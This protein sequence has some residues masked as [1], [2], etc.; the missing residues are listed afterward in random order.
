MRDFNYY[1][2]TEVVFGDQSE[3]QVAALVKKYGG[4]KVLV[5][6]CLRLMRNAPFSDPK[7][8]WPWSTCNGLQ[9]E[10][11]GFSRCRKI[12]ISGVSVFPACSS[13]S[14]LGVVIHTALLYSTRLWVMSVG[15]PVDLL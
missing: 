4:T 8:H 3:E 11:F 12:L 10:N 15:K 9:E 1:A 14:W 7:T 2:P 13:T 6:S 5:L